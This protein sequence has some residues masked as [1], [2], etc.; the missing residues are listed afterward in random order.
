MNATHTG[1]TAANYSTFQRAYDFFN[2]ELFN[3][4]LPEVLITLQR[5]SKALGYFHH[6]RFAKRS[7]DTVRQGKLACALTN[8]MVTSLSDD[9]PRVH[10]LAMNPDHFGHQTDLEICDT[11]VHE[12][13]HVARHIEGNPPRGGY[14]CK[15]WAEI[16]VNIGLQPS[17]TGKPG[18]KITGQ[19]MSDYPIEGGRFLTAYAK[20][21]KTGF[22]LDWQS[23]ELTE[24][25]KKKRKVKS[26]SKTKYTCPECDANAWG[27]P[28]ISL[29]CGDC[30]NEDEPRE[31]IVYME[32]EQ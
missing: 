10:E 3:N 17:D 31:S 7:A 27:K 22:T 9:S 8:G 21:A 12:M 4:S 26:A 28:G 29:I 13:C 6:D 15:R 5:K 25:T 18:G 19:H 11:L 23:Q 1:I 30:Y 20:L 2:R 16:M 32:A 14:H 24:E